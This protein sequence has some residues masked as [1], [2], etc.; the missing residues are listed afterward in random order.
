MNYSYSYFSR[1]KLT[2]ETSSVFV[3]VSMVFLDNYGFAILLLKLNCFAIQLLKQILLQL[4]LKR[5]LKK[6]T[7]FILPATAGGWRHSHPMRAPGRRQFGP[8]GARFSPEGGMAK[9][10]ERLVPPPP[11]PRGLMVRS[12]RTGTVLCT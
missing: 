9:E 4:L 1:Q 12:G 2:K 6:T 5:V 7:R 8:I 3:L 11:H 10:R